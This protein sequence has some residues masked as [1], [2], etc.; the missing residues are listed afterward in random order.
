MWTIIPRMLQLPSYGW[1]SRAFH[2]VHMWESF[3]RIQGWFRT[4]ARATEL[5]MFVRWKNYGRWEE[6][7]E[8]T[9]KRDD[10]FESIIFGEIKI[11]YGE[12]DRAMSLQMS[13]SDIHATRS[14]IFR[15]NNVN[16]ELVCA[17]KKIIRTIKGNSLLM[18]TVWR[19]VVN[20]KS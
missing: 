20:I 4:R 16:V 6:T 7:V 10:I 17:S 15:R 12:W 2:R 9:H 11:R 14:W 8:V 19:L 13:L 3:S 5:S 18:L 1:T